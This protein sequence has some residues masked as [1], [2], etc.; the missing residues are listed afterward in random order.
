MNTAKVRRLSRALR[1]ASARCMRNALA[2]RGYDLVLVARNKARLE[3]HAATLSA[4]TGRAARVLVADLTDARDLANVESLLRDDT[5]ITLL[6]NNAGTAAI[7]PPRDGRYRT[8]RRRDP[9]QYRRADAPRA[10]SAAGPRRARPRG[11]HQYR[12]GD[13]ADGAAGQYGLRRRQGLP[14]ASEPGA[15]AGKSKARGCGVQAVLPG[16]TRTEIW[17][18]S[19]VGLDQLPAEIIMEVDEMVDAALAGFDQGER[20][21][22]SVAARRGRL[23]ALGGRAYCVAGRTC[24]TTMRRRGTRRLKGFERSTGE[25]ARHPTEGLFSG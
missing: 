7:G 10:R 23:A 6:V 20:G 13:V 18:R 3:A 22:D 9:A 5:S 4:E 1:R 21:D 2:Q 24:R 11:D 8:A 16:A 17:D 25:N 15:R 19:S 14:A 12:V